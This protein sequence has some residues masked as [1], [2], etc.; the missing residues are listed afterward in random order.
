M[1][2]RKGFTL[3]ELL[4]V[5]VILGVLLLVAIPSVTRYI[6][7]SRK[8]SYIATAKQYIRSATN[9]VNGG[10]FDVFDPTV[11]YYIPAKCIPLET[12]GQSPYGDFDRAYVVVTYDGNGF[13]YYWQSRDVT[14]MGIPKVTSADDLTRDSV[15]AGVKRNEV[16]TTD[17]LDNTYRVNVLS[18]ETCALEHSNDNFAYLVNED[19]MVTDDYELIPQNTLSVTTVPNVTFYSKNG[20]IMGNLHEAATS[21]YSQFFSQVQYGTVTYTDNQGYKRTKMFYSMPKYRNK[22]DNSIH[23]V[24]KI[25]WIQFLTFTELDE[26]TVDYGYACIAHDSSVNMVDCDVKPVFKPTGCSR[27]THASGCQTFSHNDHEGAGLYAILDNND[28]V[29]LYHPQV[30]FMSMFSGDTNG[31]ASGTWYAPYLLQVALAD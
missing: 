11:T 7:D 26:S 19:D 20:V 14:G 22:K 3:I 15:E 24:Q 1:K 21:S 6:N 25:V 8:D 9:M 2:N 18:E 17:T 10:E 29:S 27:T 13:K 12:G 4:A 28:I 30:R 5:I 23:T 16:K 31:M